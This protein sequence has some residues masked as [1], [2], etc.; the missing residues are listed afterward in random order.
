MKNIIDNKKNEV[1]T[2]QVLEFF[3]REAKIE[4]EKAENRRKEMQDQLQ[5]VTGGKNIVFSSNSKS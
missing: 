1:S 2:K 3:M 4:R 5:R